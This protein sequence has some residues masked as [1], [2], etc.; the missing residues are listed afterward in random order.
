MT[1]VCSILSAIV[2]KQKSMIIFAVGAVSFLLSDAVLSNAYL[3]RNLDKSIH[4]FLNH[5]LYYAGQYLIA[6]SVIFV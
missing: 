4:I 6:S 2:T 5:F 3:G 1:A